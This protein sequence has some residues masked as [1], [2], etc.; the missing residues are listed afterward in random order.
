MLTPPAD[1]LAHTRD[2]SEG[3]EARL[4][5]KYVEHE[6]IN[7]LHGMLAMHAIVTYLHKTNE[8][9]NFDR[10]HQHFLNCRL[11]LFHSVHYT[12]GLHC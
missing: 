12:K 9:E 5:I 4:P 7:Y 8:A 10:Q 2:N 1:R 11:F 6:T 3:A